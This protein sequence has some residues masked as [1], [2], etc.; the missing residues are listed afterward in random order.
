M[1]LLKLKHKFDKKEI[2]KL[3]RKD[4][5]MMK[6]SY[7]YSRR[8]EPHNNFL[9]A[10][11]CLI[12]DGTHNL[13]NIKAN[14]RIFFISSTRHLVISE[15]DIEE[16]IQIA[17]REG[18]ILFKN[19]DTLELTKSGKK[20]TEISYINNLETSFYMRIFFSEKTVMLGSAIFL[21]V[22][23]FLKIIIGFQLNSQAMITDGFENLTDLVKIAI[24]V[25]LAL[26]YNKEKFASIIIIALM[27]FTGGSLI[28]AGI[29]ALF[30]PSVVIPSVQA[31]LI[32]FTSLILNLGLMYLK[33]MVG[34]IS[35]NLA[36]LSD[37]KDSQMNMML[38]GGVIIGLIFAIFGFYFIDA[39]IG[40]II[41]VVIFK[42]GIE[43]L[44]EIIVK[45]ED[46]DITEVKVYGDNIYE[47]R[48]TAYILGSIRREI[49]S[50]VQLI[51]NF[52][53][54][55]ELGRKYYHGFADFFYDRLDEIT[56]E[57]HISKL[58]MDDYI[59][60]LDG[61]LYLTQLGLK[62]FY[63]AKMREFKHRM[64]NVNV[65]SHFKIHHIYC[66]LFIILF[67]LLMLFT[68]QINTWLQ[69][70]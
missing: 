17:K 26:K 1:S 3:S 15:E 40:I 61:K 31:F 6:K 50:K 68:P 54:G 2:S 49:L 10:L 57:K 59:K 37:S 11:L 33:G 43:I 55:L 44:K 66:L 34:R 9:Y 24:I 47:N 23:S 64:K 35:G 27:F 48:L 67:I 46:F 7:P 18:L 62:A 14:M 58:I 65:G 29:E 52:S 60:E 63:K 16:Y 39:V 70:L 36:L 41:A 30:Y 69:S 51:A 12:Y 28:W 53:K 5:Q 22:L 19:Q 56:A 45:E 13:E 20:L 32:S 8:G 42:E 25:L 21:L 4:H 38:S